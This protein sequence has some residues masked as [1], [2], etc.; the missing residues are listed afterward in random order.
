MQVKR[1]IQLLER[2]DPE[3]E[4]HVSENPPG[5]EIDAF[6]TVSVV[7]RRG[8]PLLCATMDFRPIVI[9]VGCGMDRIPVQPPRP[10]DLG[11]YDDQQ[12]AARVRDFYTVHQGLDSPLAYPD[13]DYDSWIP[14]RMV[15]GEYNEHIARI[16]RDKLLRE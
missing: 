2:F 11:Q 16:L 7:D 3:S 15:S 5:C 1:L 12:T 10:L 6:D 4:V 8:E 9:Y 13:F 14:P